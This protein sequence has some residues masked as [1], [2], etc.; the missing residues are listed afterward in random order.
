MRSLQFG[1][2]REIA[3]P[4]PAAFPGPG[5]R[6]GPGDAEDSACDK[7]RRSAAGSIAA[8]VGLLCLGLLSGCGALTKLSEIGRPPAMTP[9]SDPTKDPDWRPMSLP[10]PARQPPPNEPDA[11]WR[12]GSRAFFKDQRA[13]QV[14]DVITIVVN[15]SDAA[16][17]NNVTTGTRTS[18]E[19]AGAPN[20]FGME[21]LL[22]KNIVDPSKLMSISSGN[23]NVG[24]G[25]IQR[26]ETV[27]LT[28]AG[29]VTQVLPNGNLVVAA[30]QQFRVNDELRD[31]RVTGVIRTQDITSENTVQSSQIAEAR[32]EYG[33]RGQLTDIQAPRWG[34]QV[35]DVLL[36]F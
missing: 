21:A 6:P 7:E 24:T 30:R 29:V 3:A 15:M 2:C 10:M 9:S 31:L 34:Q 18:S 23:S 16:T 26:N 19:S 33:G 1:A 32:I 25:Q 4:T 11:L 27:T 13:A 28:L 17:L 36:P 5:R 20:F 22:P 12:S 8:I 35:M 14:G